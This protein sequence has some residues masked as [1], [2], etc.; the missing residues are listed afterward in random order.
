MVFGRISAF[1][2]L[3]WYWG[4]R[5]H[6]YRYGTKSIKIIQISVGSTRDRMKISTVS[7]TFMFWVCQLVWSKDRIQEVAPHQEDLENS[8]AKGK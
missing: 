6:R 3:I 2:K 7:M 4:A 1:T 5:G 8:S